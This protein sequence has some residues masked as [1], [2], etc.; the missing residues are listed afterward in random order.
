MRRA[1]APRN[2]GQNLNEIAEQIIGT[3][4]PDAG[5]CP[6]AMAASATDITDQPTMLASHEFPL[7]GGAKSRRC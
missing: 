4:H 3:Y 7:P 2:I 6:R 1:H 5:E